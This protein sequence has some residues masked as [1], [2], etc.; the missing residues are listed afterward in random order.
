MRLEVVPAMKGDCLLLHHGTKAD[1]KLILVDGGPGGVYAKSLKPRLDRIRQE[2]VSGGH[3]GENEPLFIDLVVVSHV[4]DDHING[5]IALFEDIA[6]AAPFTVGR[7]WH[8]SF[9]SLVDATGASVAALTGPG[10][11]VTASLNSAGL[12]SAA[13]G[14]DDLTMVL[15]SIPQGHTLLGLAKKLDIP[16]NPEFQSRAIEAH[17]GRA[18]F[19]DGLRCTFLGPMRKELE[20]LR[21][22]FAKWLAKRK[23]GA[24][25]ADALLAS[26]T[27]SSV[28]NLSSLV[29]L[30]EDGDESLLLTGDAR[31]D[32]MVAAAKA[33]NLLNANGELPVETFKVPHHGSD[34]NNDKA[35]FE[36]FPAQRYVF[37][38]DGKH[39]NPERETFEELARARDEDRI[40]VELT[41]PPH[42]IDAERSAEW[43]KKRKR[44]YKL[45]EFDQSLHGIEPVLAANP[46]FIVEHP[47]SGI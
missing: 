18:M 4:D 40:T 31:G 38:G 33:L 13:D 28:P 1:P 29:I 36:A 9:D 37:S 6:N 12:G 25:T 15:A 16:V 7:L 20:D 35:T 42:E 3:I 23:A 41:Y 17:D 10:A 26:L 5:I 19:M 14:H 39:G 45:P 27:D 24:G 2:R 22:E 11:E 30:V 21:K 47:K 8:N 32:K 34:R 46:S 44:N 43:K